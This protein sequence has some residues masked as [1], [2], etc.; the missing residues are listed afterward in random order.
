MS[1]RVSTPI[2][3]RN[4]Q[5]EADIDVEG[6]VT[7]DFQH[8]PYG[9]TTVTEDISEVDLITTVCPDCGTAIDE[10]EAIEALFEEEKGW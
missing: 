1:S 7:I 3:C 5:C 4:E 9:S 10:E 8:L 6:Y 2:V